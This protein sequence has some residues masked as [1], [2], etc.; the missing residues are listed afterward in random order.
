MDNLRFRR[1]RKADIESFYVDIPETI[2][3]R[4]VLWMPLFKMS[5]AAC[6][7]YQWIEMP[8]SP[9]YPPDAPFLK[10]EH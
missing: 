7:L 9:G 6:I 10:R 1:G 3:E 8:I 5:I 4:V 2:N